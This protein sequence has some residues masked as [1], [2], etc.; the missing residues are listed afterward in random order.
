MK[1]KL[2]III[3]IIIITICIYM[4]I[5]FYLNPLEMKINSKKDAEKY[6][7]VVNDLIVNGKSKDRIEKVLKFDTD[8][9]VLGNDSEIS[10]KPSK[11]IIEKYKLEKYVDKHNELIKSLEEKIKNNFDIDITKVKRYCN[12]GK[13]VDDEFKCSKYF[14]MVKVSYKSFYY[15]TYTSD[16]TYIE[17]NL[18][19]MSGTEYKEKPTS[20]KDIANQYKAKVK[21]MQLIN[22]DDYVNSSET[23][24]FKIYLQSGLSSKNKDEVEAYLYVLN[25]YDYKNIKVN[26]TTRL[27]TYLSSVSNKNVLKLK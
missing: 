22:M 10:S 13:V 19:G 23:S 2:L 16:L 11:E 4:A 24:S 18:L 14:Y 7:N 27:Q 26:D 5:F 20:E 12:G 21:A 25:G 6:V 3:P 8:L 17:S 15:F 9:I 1:K